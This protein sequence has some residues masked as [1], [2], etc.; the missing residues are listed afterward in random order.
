MNSWTL[1][2][3]EDP[4]TGDLYLEFPDDLMDSCGWVVGDSILWVD[5]KDGSWSLRKSDGNTNPSK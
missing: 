2:V 1:H 5:N 3:K 4:S